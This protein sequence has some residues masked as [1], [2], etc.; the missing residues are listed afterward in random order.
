MQPKFVT[1]GENLP[2][3]QFTLKLLYCYKNIGS[4]LKFLWLKY[5]QLFRYICMRAGSVKD[6]IHVYT[7]GHIDATFQ[8]E[9]KWISLKIWNVVRVW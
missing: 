8:N 5:L 9:M 1:F 6:S 7:V 3:V 4:A 2:R